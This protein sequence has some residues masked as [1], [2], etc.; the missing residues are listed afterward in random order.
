MAFI[1]KINDAEIKKVEQLNN[2]PN[3]SGGYGQ[4]KLSAEQLKNWFDSYPKVVREKV[5]EI[6]DAFS[7]LARNGDYIA[8]YS[9]VGASLA[10]LVEAITSGKLAEELTVEKTGDYPPVHV[11]LVNK[12][13][14][15]IELINTKFDKVKKADGT[16]EDT[17]IT[18]QI[19][20]DAVTEVKIADG[21]VT[22]DKIAS[23][24]VTT[25]KILDKAVTESKLAEAVQGK[26][27]DPIKKIDYNITS[28]DLEIT[29]NNGGTT[30]LPL[31]LERLVASG[32]LVGEDIVLKFD[33]PN[34][35][36]LK[37]PVGTLL[38]SVSA[39]IEMLKGKIVKNLSIKTLSDFVTGDE[40]Y[41]A[42]EYAD[43]DDFGGSF[44]Y[45]LKLNEII[46]NRML[47]NN[48]VTEPKI[49]D[50]AVTTDKLDNSAVTTEKLANDSVT[51]DKIADRSIVYK[52]LD[53]LILQAIQNSLRKV[54]YDS[55]SGKLVTSTDVY[56]LTKNEIPLPIPN[57]ER[58]IE[59]LEGL[60]LKTI[61]DSTEAYEKVVPAD[62]GKYA[63]INK[64]GGKVY[65]KLGNN[66]LC[67]GDGVYTLNNQS[68][69]SISLATLDI[70]E[71]YLSF[72]R[73][74]TGIGDMRLYGGEYDTPS[75]I[76]DESMIFT[77]STKSEISLS[78]DSD[79]IMG[80]TEYL[81]GTLKNF[82][83]CKADDEDKTYKPYQP[84][85]LLNTKPTSLES[86]GAQLFDE[87]AITGASNNKLVPINAY[88]VVENGYLKA[89][90]ST[91]ASSVYWLPF[92]IKLTK[93]TYTISADIYVGNVCPSLTIVIG[94]GDG[95]KLPITAITNLYAY[96]TWERKSVTIT[97][98][99]DNIYY[100][101]ASGMGDPTNY[102]KLD[103]RFKDIQIQRGETATEFHPF[104]A[105]PI[106]TLE[107]PESVQSLEGWG[108][109]IDA[110]YNNHI[111]WRNGRVIYRQMLGEKVFNG[112]EYF[113]INQHL[114]NDGVKSYQTAFTSLNGVAPLSNVFEGLT[115]VGSKKTY[116]IQNVSGSGLVFITD[117][118]QTLDEFKAYL[119]EQY[120]SGNP[121]I[122][123]YALAEP[124]E[125]DITHLFTGDFPFI[126]VEQGGTL[127]FVNEEGSEDAI[128]STVTYITKA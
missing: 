123:V 112:T 111:E 107:L 86:R 4:A 74:L 97:L 5:D 62:V 44:N 10:D 41:L 76:Y 104:S 78:I 48:A 128:P 99:E 17:I 19:A 28:G 121:V 42:I 113:W 65:R 127:K 1:E 11:S 39:D 105:E 38:T 116:T 69:Y 2:R 119:A 14:K 45:T 57:L 93:G 95:L 91:Y 40:D 26:L 88:G 94:L 118:V 90:Y 7:N 84:S 68:S 50:D 122:V 51:T 67:S 114:N 96:D 98:A 83:L 13:E 6:I 75:A 12:L 125:T 103:V 100:F 53:Q 22:T 56:G 87:S 55:A 108:L 66:N 21:S 109:G 23:S 82:M 101:V 15:L 37:I 16:Y 52:H 29:Y 27:N 3:I 58:R 117:G 43:S 9:P 47:S 77:V 72:D 92:S 59:Q 33:D 63:V 61:E 8:L 30:T 73:D 35:E 124:I 49:A 36:P 20:N 25:D 106:D 64:V 34:I 70:G 126:E 71:Y 32:E 79:A 89:K 31:P 80:G 46:T 18:E 102:T 110:E 81:N 85:M 24:A 60:T 54:S 120:N 115:W